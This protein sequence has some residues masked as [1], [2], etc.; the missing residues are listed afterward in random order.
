MAEGRVQ[1]RF[2]AV[3]AAD[4]VGYS[5]MVEAD[6]VDQNARARN[7]MRLYRHS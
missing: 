4:I 7:Q 1:R 3:M 2:A 5:R 6:G